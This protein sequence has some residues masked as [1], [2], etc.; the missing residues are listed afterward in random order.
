MERAMVP[1]LTV[2]NGLTTADVA[3]GESL[4][5]GVSWAAVIA[6]A[7]AAAALSL[8]LLALG[9]G[10]GFSA[11]SPWS[12]SGASAAAVGAAALVWLIV[13]EILASAMGGYLAGR[14]RTKWATIH[15]DEVYFR[16]TA[17]GLLAWATGLVVTAA[18]LTSAAATMVGASAPAAVSREAGGA[19]SERANPSDYLTGLLFRGDRSLGAQDD[20]AARDEARIVFANALRHKAL[21][22]D[23]QAYVGQLVANKTGLDQTDAEKRVSQVFAQAQQA[24]DTARHA[25]AELSLCLF[26]ALLAGAFVASFTATI[27]G[28]QRDHVKAL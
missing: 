21:S 17:H 15:S 6:G 18:L 10:L 23:D 9:A 8:V 19:A 2:D 25:A 3:G 22:P 28:R 14:L 24:A 27:G 1:S 20:A 13:A 4:A 26:F 7:L 16:D 11:V 12:N 5:S